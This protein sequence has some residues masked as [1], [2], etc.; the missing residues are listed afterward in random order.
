MSIY[1]LSMPNIIKKE[2]QIKIA[3][4]IFIFFTFWWLL[5]NFVF[6]HGSVRYDY[7]GDWSDLYGIMAVWGGV[8]GIA[9][10]RKWGGIR[11]VMGKAILF[12]SFGLFAQE[13]GQLSYSLYA[14]FFPKVTI[15]PSIG[16]IGFSA[17]IIFYI[18]GILFLARAS[19]VHISLRSFKN[20]IP[21]IV[22]PLI[23]LIVG[24]QL[25]LQNYIFDWAN[26]LKIFLD[27]GYPL[28]DACYISLAILA[29]LLSRG[30]LGGAMRN[31]ILFILFALVMQFITDYT[32]LYQ[33][34]RGT[35]S[36][37]AIDDYMYFLAYFLMTVGLLQLKT[38]LDKI[39]TASPQQ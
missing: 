26:P 20:K 2:W 10:A 7:F 6:P 27:F 4:L 30:I 15:Y 16:D 12:F 13:F 19:G 23:M 28:G 1:I 29:Y 21:A 24:Y 33:S 36:V 11:S 34:S 39:K 17:T 37:G 22:I 9:I 31:K 35:Y 5:N 8:W 14:D 32:Y 25:F 18:S 3:I 38:V